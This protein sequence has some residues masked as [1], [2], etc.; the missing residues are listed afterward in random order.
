MNSRPYVYCG[1]DALDALTQQE[2]L[3]GEVIARM[4]PIERAGFDDPFAAL[5]HSVIGQLI[6]RKAADTVW[7]RLQNRA[8]EITPQRMANLSI[9]ELRSCGLSERKGQSLHAIAAAIESGELDFACAKS[10]TDQEIIQQLIALP[11]IGVWTAE[12]LLLFALDRRDVV[13]YMDLGIRGGMM[14]LY[15]IEK[16]SKKQFQVLRQ[17][18]SPYGSTASLYLWA[19]YGE[20]RGEKDAAGI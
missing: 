13:S 16:L 19:L 7:Q 2:P 6:S 10:M 8:G 20:A 3:L 1:K 5:V 9:E 12:M 18:Y 15:G 4:G 17:K 11:G 14:R